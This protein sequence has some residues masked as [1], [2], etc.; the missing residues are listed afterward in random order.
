MFLYILCNS[1]AKSFSLFGQRGEWFFFF[2]GISV[3][4]PLKE[5]EQEIYVFLVLFGSS[6]W[7]S[8]AA[9]VWLCLCLLHATLASVQYCCFDEFEAK[10]VCGVCAF[11]FDALDL[12]LCWS[13][14][15]FLWLCFWL[16]YF[17]GHVME[18]WFVMEAFR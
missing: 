18:L 14:R 1:I 6:D 5:E 2:P 15:F 17:A 7:S 12:M 9:R 13:L 16:F 4:N 10:T 8:V 3:R 11:C